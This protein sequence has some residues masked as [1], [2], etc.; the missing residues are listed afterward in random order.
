MHLITASR[1]TPFVAIMYIVAIDRIKGNGGKPNEQTTLELTSLAKEVLPV[2][3]AAIPDL[4]SILIDIVRGKK[5]EEAYQKLGLIIKTILPEGRRDFQIP[6]E[7][8]NKLT[9]LGIYFRTQSNAALSK[10]IKNASITKNSWIVQSLAPTVGSQHET[11]RA[12]NA[13]IKSLVGHEGTALTIDEANTIKSTKP[14]AYKAYLALR[15]AFNQSWRDALVSFIRKSGEKTIP[16]EDA[17]EY[18]HLNG[19]E[20]LMPKGFTGRI[21]DLSRFY[22]DDNKLIEGVPNAITFPSVKMNHEYGMDGDWVF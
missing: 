3:S 22:T 8:L 9:A 19:I 10:I 20:H 15:K 16:Y 2:W 6:S 18:L 1:A 17:L 11:K 14:D 4:R 21:D 13:L 12:L 7:D 5:K